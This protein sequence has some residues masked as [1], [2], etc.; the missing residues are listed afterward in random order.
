LYGDLRIYR[1]MKPNLDIESQRELALTDYV[2][3]SGILIFVSLACLCIVLLAHGAKRCATIPAEEPI[4]NVTIETTQ[5]DSN[6]KAKVQPGATV[7]QQE[8]HY[9]YIALVSPCAQ[10]SSE[11]LELPAKPSHS[12]DAKGKL[13]AP[14]LQGAKVIREHHA[15]HRRHTADFSRRSD[16][17]ERSVRRNIKMLIEM[18]H[19][20][21]ET[22]KTGRDERRW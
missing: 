22:N 6:A 9:N 1:G 3:I 7:A 19:R 12:G 17:L 21:V 4:A 10:S 20:A 11:T 18:W 14:G 15:Q 8:P 5:S 2:R 16:S 13:A